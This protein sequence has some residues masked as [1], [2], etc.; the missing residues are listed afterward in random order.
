ML[1]TCSH[2]TAAVLHQ[3]MI[4]TFLTLQQLELLLLSQGQPH[5]DN[6]GT[7]S[8]SKTISKMLLFRITKA[9]KSPRLRA[10]ETCFLLLSLNLLPTVT[11]IRCQISNNL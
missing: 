6:K 1:P 8:I 4:L 3:I 11:I 5:R 9:L 10:E 7:N 2:K